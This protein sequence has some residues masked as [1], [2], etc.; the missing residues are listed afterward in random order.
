MQC[1]VS[2]LPSFFVS[3]DVKNSFYKWK[4]LGRCGL[5]RGLQGPL[6]AAKVPHS[7]NGPRPCGSGGNGPP[8]KVRCNI[9]RVRL[10]VN[11]HHGVIMGLNIDLGSPLG[12][13]QTIPSNNSVAAAS[14]RQT[15]VMLLR[16]ILKNAGST[17]SPVEQQLCSYPL[18]LSA[19]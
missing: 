8:A 16:A 19:S 18:H 10:G 14:T 5:L 2:W 6:A 7:G 3:F 11:L 15:L 1:F 12:N 4:N 13:G 9:S 17:F